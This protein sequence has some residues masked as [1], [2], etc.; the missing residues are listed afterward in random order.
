L[1]TWQDRANTHIRQ[2]IGYMPGTIYHHW[3]GRKKDRRY[4]ERWQILL[5]HGYDPDQDLQRDWQGLYR[6][7]DKGLRMRADL[8]EY[9][10]IRNED[11]TEL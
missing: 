7:S 9:F 2:N 4:V 11:S 10:H 3:H 6:L 8:R 1:L 5:K